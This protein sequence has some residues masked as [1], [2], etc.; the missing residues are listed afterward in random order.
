[1][2]DREPERPQQMVLVGDASR[3]HDNGGDRVVD[4]FFVREN[5]DTATLAAAGQLRDQ[6]AATPLQ[7]FRRL[8]RRPSAIALPPPAHALPDRPET[9]GRDPPAGYRK[10]L[11]H[12]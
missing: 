12:E 11:I 3:R 5:G 4:D 10:P 8:L 7:L 6:L 2:I 1:M 9:Q